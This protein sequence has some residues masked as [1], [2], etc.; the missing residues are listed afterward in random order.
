MMKVKIDREECIS[1]AAC[2]IDC[3]FFEESPADGMSQVAEAYQTNSAPDGGD[4]P[5]DLEDCV[6]EAA[7]LCPVAIIHV[8]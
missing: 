7:D 8:D 1:C 4:V 6:E 2:W 5:A 3:L